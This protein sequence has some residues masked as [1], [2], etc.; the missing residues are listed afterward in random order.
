MLLYSVFYGN[1]NFIVI[2]VKI[3]V[4]GV[5]FDIIVMLF[6]KWLDMVFDFEYIYRVSC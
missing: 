1:W 5:N 3:R 4:Y 6:L 2:E